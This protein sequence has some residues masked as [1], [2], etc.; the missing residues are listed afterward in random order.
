MAACPYGARSFNFSDPRPLLE[1]A[2]TYRPEYPTR[3]RGAVEK[4]TFCP[5]RLR[6]GREPACVEAARSVPGGAGA[7]TF[8]DLSDP[9]SEVS[10]LLRER[11]TQCRR[12]GLG[13]GPNV[14]YIL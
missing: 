8:G 14:Y 5:E 12:V 13:F 11:H 3:T 10:R 9:D 4:C 2:G 1:E 6:E 7:L